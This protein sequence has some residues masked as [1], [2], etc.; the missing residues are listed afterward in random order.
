MRGRILVI[1]HMTPTPDQDSGSTSTFNFLR[2]LARAGFT[3]T[4]VPVTLRR[5]GKYS[6]AL[7]AIGITTLASPRWPSVDAVI[8]QLAPQA[9]V[10]L[11]YRAPIATNVF[12]RTRNAAPYAKILFHPVDLHFL[13]MQRAA[14]LS[15]DAADAEEAR[16]MRDVELGLIRHTDA[17]IVVSEYEKELLGEL[18]PGAAVHRIPIVRPIPP[19]PPSRF[20]WRGRASGLL[21][22]VGRALAAARPGFEQRRDVVFI[23][24]YGHKPNVDA[25]LWF[26]RD[27][28][29]LVLRRGYGGKLIVAGSNVPAEVSALVSN[30]IE[31][32]GYVADLAELFASCRLSIAPLRYGGGVK[33]KIVSSLSYGVPVVATSIAAE[34]MGL[35]HDHD[36]LIGDEPDTMA[37][38]IV[39]L[40]GDP[41]LWRRLSRNGYETFVRTFS[42]RASAKK[43]VRVFDD[44]VA[45]ARATR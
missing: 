34:G 43:I 24:G 12:T 36:V 6:E 10:A 19:A 13:R 37:D 33:G 15:G 29:P 1:D 11:L 17:T 42:E 21:G 22:R 28:W 2:I 7:E 38:A 30:T 40:Y 14:D 41:A 26:C 31:V 20:G 9:D 16:R 44:L 35:R 5:E 18:V 8:D 3:L 45:A 32:R 4:F 39:R 25:I 27:V 23:G